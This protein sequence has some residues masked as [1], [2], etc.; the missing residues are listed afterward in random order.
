M[1]ETPPGVS[2]PVPSGQ[3]R[4][5]KTQ[6]AV[7]G[8]CVLGEGQHY[9]NQESLQLNEERWDFPGSPVD[10][11][12]PLLGPWVPPLVGELMKKINQ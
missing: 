5:G 6:W 9:D 11:A 3:R 1:V 4:T 10:S 12:L 2:R 8:S 7:H